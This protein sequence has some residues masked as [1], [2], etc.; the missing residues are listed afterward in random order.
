MVPR[1]HQA[2]TLVELLVVIGI[3]GLLIGILLP[4]LSAAQSQAQRLKCASNLRTL[5][6][7]ALHYANDNRGLIPRDYTYGQPGHLFWAEMFARFMKQPMPPPTVPS[8]LAG[9][10]AMWPY[11][12]R[13]G[14]LQCPVFPD[15]R[16]PVD[17]VL[18]GWNKDAAGGGSTSPVL[19]ITK[20]SRS[21]QIILATE[22][23][24]RMSVEAM[25]KHD[26]W[27]VDHLPTG[28][29]NERRV[30]DDNRHRGLVNMVYLDGHVG[31]CPFGQLVAG[32]FVLP[33]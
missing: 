3:I 31:S 23:N 4:A 21:A 11:L 10:R 8:S 14:W 22:G 26:V 27:A 19:Q 24:V 6:Q 25:D 1:P 16:Q 13:I 5:G 12:A 20:I 33:K 7:V 30:C 29:M 32:D 28:P 17:F 9:D 2:F 15:E 18:N